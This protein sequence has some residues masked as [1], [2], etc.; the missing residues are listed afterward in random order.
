MR[1]EDAVKIEELVEMKTILTKQVKEKSS[2]LNKM[3]EIKLPLILTSDAIRIYENKGKDFLALE[4]FVKETVIHAFATSPSF[5]NEV[6]KKIYSTVKS[7]ISKMMDV[8]IIERERFSNTC[9][10]D[11]VSSAIKLHVKGLVVLIFTLDSQEAN[12]KMTE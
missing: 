6:A 11:L 2:A 12:T 3:T 10:V 4:G 7:K 5:M 8:I 1:E 9:Y